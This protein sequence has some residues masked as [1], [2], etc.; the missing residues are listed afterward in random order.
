M[1]KYFLNL[2]GKDGFT[3]VDKEVYRFNKKDDDEIVI[4][5]FKFKE[6]MVNPKDQIVGYIVDSNKPSSLQYHCDDCNE[7]LSLDDAYRDSD[8][9]YYHTA[10]GFMVEAKE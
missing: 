4:N 1:L 10:C 5:D 9:Y 7:D 2:K 3:E 6:I 8:G